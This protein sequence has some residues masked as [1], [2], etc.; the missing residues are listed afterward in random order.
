MTRIYHRT[1]TVL[2]Y[3]KK[4][5]TGELVGRAERE[6]AASTLKPDA[7]NAAVGSIADV[8]GDIA[9]NASVFL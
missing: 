8:H 5:N 3:N 1:N 7:D 4:V 9:E 6:L 2:R